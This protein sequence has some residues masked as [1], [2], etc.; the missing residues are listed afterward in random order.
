MDLR[1]VDLNLL[2]ILDQVLR[3]GHVTRASVALSM[4]QPAVSNAVNRLRRLLS[5]PLL[6]RTGRSVKLTPFAEALR[7]KIRAVLTEVEQTLTARPTFDPKQDERTFTLAA[8]DYMT[9]VLLRS[10]IESL[11][12]KA[13]N[14]RIVV[15]PVQQDYEAQLREDR[16]DLIFM[17]VQPA[18]GLDDINGEHLFFDHFVLALW[19]QHP[20]VDVDPESLLREEPY[21]AW[22]SQGP[23]AFYDHLR[24]MKILLRKDVR[25]E[26]LMTVPFVLSGTRLVTIIHERLV[27]MLRDATD[28][29]TR[30][31]PTKMPPVSQRMFWHPRRSEDA[32]HQWLRRTVLQAAAELSPTTSRPFAP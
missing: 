16:E 20:R 21:L 6:V 11:A 25:L 8:T 9:V 5:D 32:G 18:A 12:V 23:S 14:V 7:P 27:I 3:E 4:S 29:V 28:L 15:I 22:R 26:S 13:P 17:P 31:L 30:P 10:V 1:R 24:D 19:K 2:V